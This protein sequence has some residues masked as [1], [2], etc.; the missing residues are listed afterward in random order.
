[1]ILE[2]KSLLASPAYR[3]AGFTKGGTTPL[4]Q[5]GVVERSKD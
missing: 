1:L 4:W 5:R 2:I 3:Q